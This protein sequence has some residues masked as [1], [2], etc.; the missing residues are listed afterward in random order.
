M[1]LVD[2]TGGSDR[3]YCMKHQCN[4]WDGTQYNSVVIVFG[5]A[6]SENVTCSR[7]EGLSR[8]TKSVTSVSGKEVTCPDIDI[9]CGTSSGFGECYWGHWSDVEGK[10]LCH[11][12]YTGSD[13]NS[14]DNSTDV[15]LVQPA[16][17]APTS[18]PSSLLCLQGFTS[19]TTYNGDW[20]YYSASLWRP[21]ASYY[22][23]TVDRFVYW[24]MFDHVWYIVS[25]LG[26]TGGAGYCYC[27]VSEFTGI[28]RGS[29]FFWTF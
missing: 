26:D 14:K 13:C 18:S 3:G 4:G 27:S 21:Y 25:D 7:A 11:P 10:C 9:V 20:S 12:G 5:A 22:K 1:D 16:T 17:S 24:N 19:Y 2:T 28:L 23:T 6:G 8:S 15:E 29:I